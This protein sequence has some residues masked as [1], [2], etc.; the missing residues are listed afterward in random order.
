MSC[1]LYE[2]LGCVPGGALLGGALSGGPLPGGASGCCTDDLVGHG[3]GWL[4][5]LCEMGQAVTF[6]GTQIRLWQF[7]FSVD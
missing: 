2:L 5:V 6:T 7:T 3:P 1:C 4:G